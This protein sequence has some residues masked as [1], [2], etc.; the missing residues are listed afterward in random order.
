MSKGK[1]QKNRQIV[2]T[3]QELRLRAEGRGILIAAHDLF[4][5]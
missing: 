2:V 4:R 5:K 1:Q 3:T